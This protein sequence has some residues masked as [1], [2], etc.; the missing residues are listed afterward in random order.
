M[1]CNGSKK[2]V[3]EPVKQQPPVQKTL[4]P[5][6]ETEVTKDVDAV[7]QEKLKGSL[8]A[9]LASGELTKAVASLAPPSEAIAASGENATVVDNEA[10]DNQSAQKESGKLSD[11]LDVKSPEVP[12]SDK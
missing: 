8:D 7:L 11:V 1:G 3:A 5:P 12:L 4:L 2:A 9:A 6:P 10:V